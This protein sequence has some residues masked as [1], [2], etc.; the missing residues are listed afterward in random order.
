MLR[1]AAFWF[2]THFPPGPKSRYPGRV[3]LQFR[4]NPLAFLES[5]AREFGDIVH[6]RIGRQ[7][8]FFINHPDLIRDV[9]VTH[10]HKFLSGFDRAKKLLGEGLIT[11]DGRLHQQQRRLIQPAFH[12]ERIAK[13][14]ETITKQAERA[15]S[16]WSNGTTLNVAHEM[17][18]LTLLVV[19]ET[20][21][22]A[23]LESDASDIRH[24][25]AATIGSPPNMLMPFGQL[26]EKLPLPAVRRMK[27][28][29][30]KLDEIVYRLIK[31]RRGCEEKRGDL[32]SMLLTHDKE[33]GDAGMTDQ[34][35]RDQMVTILIA[36]HDTTAAALTWTWYLLSEH[37][38]VEA[39]LHEELDDVLGNR[40]PTFADTQALPFTENVI[41]E[42]LRIYPPVWMMWRRAVEDYEVDGYIAPARSIVVMSQHVMHRDA[43][44][45]PEP[46][47]F[48][49][50]RWTGEF[51]A[52]LPKYTYF[53]FG[54][55]PRQCIGESFA[56][57][58]AILLIATLAQQWK[59]RLVPGQPVIPQTLLT[60][61]PR[62]GLSMTAFRR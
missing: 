19:G 48:D 22:G 1:I 47:R 46:L 54:G 10:C 49:P 35:V 43:R 3:F 36:G 28:G 51:K 14:A 56:W 8:T 34:Q 5:A 27:T 7:H 26:V 15:R 20:L 21:F 2:M 52:A 31:D 33:E 40:L 39:R 16:H 18:R 59:F 44:Y 37:P 17:M 42:S 45:F 9:L 57:M 12:R 32:L 60:Q 62:H 38:E 23:N 24:A 55:G 58:E 13:F 30:A 50:E 6:W 11:S 4:K 41:R 61:R 29:R 25:L 53:P